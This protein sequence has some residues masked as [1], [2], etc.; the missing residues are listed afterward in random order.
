MLNSVLAGILA[1]VLIGAGA[2]ELLTIPQRLPASQIADEGAG[3]ASRGERIFWA[4][5]CSSCHA[6]KDAK[7]EEK[8]KLGGGAPL[9]T[10]FGTFYAPNISPDPVDGIG[11]WTLADF[12]NA[13]Q[14]GVD[15]EGRHLYPAFP[16]TSYVKLKPGDVA[17]LW[18]F[19]K[20][21]PK[22]EGQAPQNDLPFPFNI[23]RGIGLWKLVFMDGSG[24]VIDLPADA[25]KAAHD[26]Q[27]LVEGPGHCGQCHTPRSFGGAG[28]LMASQWLA[29]A[30]N[31]E[32][33]GKVPNITPSKAGIGSWSAKD[34]AY[35]LESGF[36][37]DFDSVGGSM[38]DVQENM[39]RLPA[40]DREAIAVYLKAIPARGGPAV[41]TGEAAAATN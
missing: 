2:F 3:E 11:G 32:G 6:A 12:A 10:E 9:K 14:R 5:G 8:L 16:Y 31:P 18:A 29:G 15:D 25:P 20:T 4:G 36:T 34:I 1:I 22:I 17:D 33:K 7:G 38:V 21:L 23:R 41:G 40:A 27:Y 35:F 19:L 30:P 28:A 26:G 39:A 37:P 13:L 24:P